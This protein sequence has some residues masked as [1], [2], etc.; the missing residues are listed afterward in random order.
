MADDVSPVE[1]FTRRLSRSAKMAVTSAFALSLGCSA[2]QEK[3]AIETVLTSPATRQESFEATLR[4]LDAHPEYVDEFFRLT[5]KHPSTL[6]RFLD[7]DARNLENDDLARRTAAHL[8]AHPAGL[9]RIMLKTLDAISDKPL[10]MSAVAK[11]MM[12]RPQVAAMVL[13]QREDAIRATLTAL[14]KEVRKN[15]RA[16]RAFLNG[17]EENSDPLAK[18][19]ADNPRVLG[20][21]LKSMAGIGASKGK[22]ELGDLMKALSNPE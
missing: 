1:R 19:L 17:M 9:Y 5:L 10:A 8:A 20:R 13:A 2:A 21:L 22:A 6:E 3:P 18:L 11:A 4:V 12:E 7:N 16:R 14:V 15:D